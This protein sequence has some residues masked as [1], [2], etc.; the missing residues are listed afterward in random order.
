MATPKTCSRTGC[1]KKLR[2]SNTK[3]VCATGCLS[4][5]APA[6]QQKDHAGEGDVLTRFRKVARAL[7]KD[8][9]AILREA[10]ERVAGDWLQTVEDAVK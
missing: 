8:P 6:S 3:G 2:P 7:G 5:D 1:D 4:A 9:D 10:M